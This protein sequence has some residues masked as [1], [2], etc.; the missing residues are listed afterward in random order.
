MH[1]IKTHYKNLS[2]ESGGEYNGGRGPASK[3]PFAEQKSWQKK[4]K[5]SKAKWKQK[6]WWPHPLSHFN[7]KGGRG[8]LTFL[9]PQDNVSYSLE[10]G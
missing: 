6:L 1:I 9:K 2:L 5:R 8:K 3:S 7:Q 4:N 10:W